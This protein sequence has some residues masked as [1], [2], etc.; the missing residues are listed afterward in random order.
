MGTNA[1]VEKDEQSKFLVKLDP[2]STRLDLKNKGLELIPE[3]I[4]TLQKLTSCNLP[5]NKIRQL[6]DYLFDLPK[7]SSLRLTSNKISDIPT[8]INKLS[9]SLTSLDISKNA[10]VNIGDQ[11]G[12]LVNL[13][14]LNI[15]NNKISKIT[16]RLDELTSL[17]SLNL[18]INKLTTVPDI[19][20][21]VN[22]ENLEISHNLITS[23][24]SCKYL[25]KL[26]TLNIAGN[27]LSIFDEDSFDGL[28]SLQTLDLQ[29]NQIISFS[30]N[31]QS[32][33]G[34]LTTLH[35]QCNLISEITST[36]GTLS[37]LEVLE[38][39]ENKLENL[40]S[41]SFGSLQ[42]LTKLL[43]YKNQMTSIP[44]D[45]GEMVE[46]KDL[47]VSFNRL[48]SIPSSLSKC[49]N[50]TFLNFSYNN[51]NSIP[52]TLFDGLDNLQEFLINQN[53]ITEL[54]KSILK[55]KNIKRIECS[56][57]SVQSNLPDIHTISDFNWLELAMNKIREIPDTIC[58][59]KNL[60]ILN[61]YGNYIERVP[62]LFG[63][64]MNLK[65]LNLG[66]NQLSDLPAE[67]KNCSSLQELI[68]SGNVFEKIPSSVLQ[69]PS[70]TELC[71]SNN[72]LVEVSPQIENLVNLKVL[73]FNS[74]RMTELVNNIGRL[75]NLQELD[76][77]HN[78]IQELPPSIICL[79]SLTD[80]DA[81]GNLLL[82]FPAGFERN[83]PLKQ[84]K[85][86]FNRL[87][88]LPN[89]YKDDVSSPKDSPEAVETPTELDRSKSQRESHIKVPFISCS[90]N[91]V[92][93][94]WYFSKDESKFVIQLNK[95]EKKFLK[96]IEKEKKKKE[97]DESSAESTP[98]NTSSNRLTVDSSLSGSG[99]KAKTS[100]DGTKD[101]DKDDSKISSSA[102]VTPEIQEPVDR[103][104]FKGSHGGKKDTNNGSNTVN[105]SNGGTASSTE[106]IG[107]KSKLIL[108]TGGATSN[109]NDANFPE[110]L[111]KI[112]KKYS[113]VD[114]DVMSYRKKLG[115][116]EMRGR[117]PDMQDTVVITPSFRDNP[118]RT[119][120]CTFDGHSGQKSAEL[121][122]KR[123]VSVLSD[124]I[125][126]LENTKYE[127]F[128]D[129]SSGKESGEGL[130]FLKAS[131]VKNSADGGRRPRFGNEQ[132]KPT[133]FEIVLTQTYNMLHSEIS[134]KGF[135]D[136]TTALSV[137]VEF[138]NNRVIIANA[139][140]QRV[141]LCR[142]GSPV[143]LTVDHKPD[144]PTEKARVYKEGG[145]VN[146]QKRV[147]GIL[148][149]SRSLGDSSLQPKVTS[150]PDIFVV[151][152]IHTTD[153]FLIIACDGVWDVLSNEEAVKIVEKHINP[154]AAAAAL[155]DAAYSLGSGD[156]L[157]V[158]VYR[159]D[160]I[161]K[162]KDLKLRTRFSKLNSLLESE[163]SNSNTTSS[164]NISSDKSSRSNSG[165]GKWTV[166]LK[167]EKDLLTASS[168]P[169]NK[170]RKSSTGNE[171][172]PSKS[173]E[174]LEV[175]QDSSNNQTTTTTKIT[176]A[177]PAK[178][179]KSPAKLKLQ[180]QN[181][182]QL[183]T[184]SSSS[185]SGI[186]SPGSVDTPK[187]SSRTDG[188]EKIVEQNEHTSTES[189]ST[190]GASLS[191]QSPP[192]TTASGSSSVTRS[193]KLKKSK[194]ED[195][196]RGK[197]KK[198]LTS[199]YL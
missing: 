44:T 179:S 65:K 11:F 123:F 42:K 169:R 10:L 22:L 30:C 142:D 121:C 174:K 137:L 34:S 161:I 60:S 183:D 117:R 36:I 166:G 102:P 158:I 35:L 55:L 157:T 144:E 135:V 13:T 118:Y 68:L 164:D 79:T 177:S 70:L 59:S 125:N 75:I 9:N 18:S 8:T 133:E 6:P 97:K 186:T 58:M 56:Q 184:T 196:K 29:G 15:N 108:A 160:D 139:G 20:S 126:D 73:R 14:E 191:N 92:L 99:D 72:Q 88:R 141:V 113:A 168:G 163:V 47:D 124:K 23:Y 85:I 63:N 190:V 110:K 50:L 12:D 98:R 27:K 188:M 149:V 69:L 111:K 81:S 39:H 45:I 152:P 62:K 93:N 32:L 31:L 109:L 80:L 151:D 100:S 3:Q 172:T 49:K 146:E 199:S 119:L 76:I 82:T 147:D 150:V 101:K 192:Q 48:K 51:I 16:P 176:T 134:E 173:S 181:I 103:D 194:S 120:I 136:G 154:V 115:W 106:T 195:F 156:N 26:E 77:S 5:S 182:P 131:K 185:S 167:A 46:L 28:K 129:L 122:A 175:T 187:D 43:L 41:D 37:Q 19:T 66:Y 21:L 7:L 2:N 140:D 94:D 71:F 159:L 197:L 153:K 128:S 83:I 33:G 90:G 193:G 4:T 116:A 148:S 84:L 96:Y 24:P 53:D 40:P 61:L 107:I 180:V 38:L 87:R 95:H 143:Q 64:L 138:D 170:V 155:R 91:V 57:N 1:S 112:V 114:Q 171:A 104:T 198:S 105:S 127:P 54:P 74:N 25:T 132:L 17:K 165:K 67:M 145:F 162:T 78:E 89:Y 130:S 178:L 86:S 52:E 189:E